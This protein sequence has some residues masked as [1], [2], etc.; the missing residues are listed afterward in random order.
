MDRS[1]SREAIARL[2]GIGGKFKASKQHHKAKA[3][4]SAG[5]QVP[6]GKRPIR[7]SRRRLG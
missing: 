6:L 5:G 1:F 2:L 7:V 4:A 3:K